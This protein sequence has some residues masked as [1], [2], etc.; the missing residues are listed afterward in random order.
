MK[1]DLHF[2]PNFVIS[3]VWKFLTQKVKILLSFFTQIRLLL[4]LTLYLVF[5]HKASQFTPCPKG[6]TLN[7]VMQWMS[8]TKSKDWVIQCVVLSA[9]WRPGDWWT[10]LAVHCLNTKQVRSMDFSKISNLDLT[11][12]VKVT[13]GDLVTRLAMFII[14]EERS[15]TSKSQ[16]S[17]NLME[18]VSFESP[19]DRLPF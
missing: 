7:T 1:N 12:I 4:T 11:Y 18:T 6:P 3:K 16:A 17:H 9:L 15:H 10:Q 14:V 5:L 8:I 2:P 13:R 19:L